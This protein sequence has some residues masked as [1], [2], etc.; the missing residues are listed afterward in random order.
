[1]NNSKFALDSLTLSDEVL[2][3]KPLLRER[4][5]KLMRTLEAIQGV[6]RTKEWSTLKT[7]L[8]DGLTDALNKQISAEAQKETPDGLKLNRLAGQLKWAEKYSDLNRLGDAFRLE[9]NNLRQQLYGT[10]KKD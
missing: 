10:T 8:F 7:E 6:T 1:M 4:E 2:D 5:A 3:T 9:L